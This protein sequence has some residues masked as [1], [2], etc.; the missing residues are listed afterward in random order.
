M[1]LQIETVVVREGSTIGYGIGIPT[2]DPTKR[3]IFAGDWRAMVGLGE[4]MVASDDV[5]ELEVPEHAIL[6]IRELPDR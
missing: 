1:K 2:N 6:E 3:V 5:I 4:A